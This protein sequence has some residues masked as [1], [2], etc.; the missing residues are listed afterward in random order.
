[1]FQRLGKLAAAN[2]WIVCVVWLALGAGL[3]LFVPHWDTYTQDDDIRF[4]PNRFTSAR[5]YELME[6]AFPQEV[7]ASRLIFALER[8]D[9]P[10]TDKDLL[11]VDRIVTDLEELKL[12]KVTSCKDG[13]LGHRMTSSDRH[14][15]LI[16]VAST[17]HS[18]P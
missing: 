3:T 2:S 7:E 10:L 15:T 16:Q 18:W 8:E 6:K 5:A 12:G 11:L 1:M 14:C 4:L 9:A 17:L 13:L